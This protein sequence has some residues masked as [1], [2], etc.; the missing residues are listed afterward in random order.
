MQMAGWKKIRK[1]LLIVTAIYV[2]IGVALYF[3]QEKFLFH[4]KA[5]DANHQFKF[6]IPFREAE[7]A[8]NDRKNMSIVQFT[9]PDSLRRG[10]VLYFHGNMQNIERYASFAGDFTRN[11]FEVWMID[12]PHFGKSTGEL[13]ENVLYND[14][15]EFYKMARAR[16]AGD[17][18]VIY[19]KSLGTGIAAHLAA[20]RDCRRLILETPYYSIDRLFKRYA[21]I[22]P[23]GLM[24][25]YHLPVADYLSQVAAPVAIFHGTDDLLIPFSH[26]K[27]LSNIDGTG[28]Q[29]PELF[30]I[31]GGSHNNLASFPSYH[32]KLDSLLQSP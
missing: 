2:A 6:S 12:Y 26:A 13:N 3:L 16:F 32:K 14:A 28:G 29:K 4:P 8:F 19:G 21:F 30:C 31:D 24:T 7:V 18:I 10:L 17:S 27:D 1:W 5:L 22:Y 20:V 9:V 23:V 11:G 25:K 15:N